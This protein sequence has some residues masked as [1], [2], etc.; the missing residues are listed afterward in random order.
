MSPAARD[1]QAPG[2]NIVASTTR[3]S[4]V[5]ICGYSE[6]KSRT[7]EVA[8][9]LRAPPRLKIDLAKM[10][11]TRANHSWLGFLYLLNLYALNLFLM[12]I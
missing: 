3:L 10:G 12:H 4:Q 9:S 11:I 6:H 2:L 8:M 7:V 5:L 1:N